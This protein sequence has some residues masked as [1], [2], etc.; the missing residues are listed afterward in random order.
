[1]RRVTESRAVLHAT[2]ATAAGGDVLMFDGWRLDCLRRGLTAPDGREVHLT[3]AEYKLLEA[4]ARN[5]NR[6][7]DRDRLMDAIAARDWQPFD[8][9]I[10]L[11][12]SNLRHKIEADPKRPRIIRTVRGAG[13]MLTAPVTRN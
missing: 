9:S 6:A 13:Y 1:L 2:G 7:L 8:R 12:M 10:D 3:T 4:L 5:P 11:H